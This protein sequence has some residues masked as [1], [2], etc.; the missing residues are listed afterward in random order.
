MECKS[1]HSQEKAP[2]TLEN[3][4]TK[5]GVVFL[6]EGKS[7]EELKKE[8]GDVASPVSVTVVS[9]HTIDFRNITIVP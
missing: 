9:L 2:A 5:V 6:K 3:V 4:L 1:F 7:Y 8:L